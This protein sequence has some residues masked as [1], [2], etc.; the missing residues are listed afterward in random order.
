[1]KRI[2]ILCTI[3]GYVFNIY[4]QNSVKDALMG[5]GTWFLFSARTEEK[6]NERIFTK[7]DFFKKEDVSSIFFDQD[8]RLF[9]VFSKEGADVWED[10][11]RMAD[12][13]HFVIVSPVDQSSQ[14]IDIIELNKKKLVIRNCSEIEG[15]TKCIIY[16]YFSTKKGWLPDKEIEELNTAGVMVV[17]KMMYE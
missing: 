16:T 9:S 8:D 4:T 12:D 14:V 15:G 13:T 11:W 7:I 1:M 3:L 17:D 5:Q 2:L 6:I 10:L